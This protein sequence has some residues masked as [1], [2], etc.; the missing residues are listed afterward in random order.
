MDHV[1]LWSLAP[2]PDSSLQHEQ[3][4]E[5]RRLIRSKMDQWMCSCEQVV[6]VARDIS[7]YPAD[8]ILDLIA[9]KGWC[10]RLLQEREVKR[11]HM[12][13]LTILTGAT[14]EELAQMDFKRPGQ[15]IWWVIKEGESHN[16]AQASWWGFLFENKKDASFTCQAHSLTHCD[17]ISHCTILL[18]GAEL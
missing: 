14:N 6:R 18:V 10:L 17:V 3:E 4:R 12:L 13:A 1:P 2:W 11:A 8:D 16:L 7:C 9:A 15:I 5:R